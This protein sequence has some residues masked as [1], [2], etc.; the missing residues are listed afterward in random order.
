MIRAA[1]LLLALTGCPKNVEV[2]RA[3]TPA[4]GSP[5]SRP[6]LAWLSWSDANTLLVC[7][8]RVDDQA[9]TVGTPG[10]CLRVRAEQ[11]L[12]P[13]VAFTPA[14]ADRANA[15]AAPWSSCPLTL[16]DAQSVPARKAA[17]IMQRTPAGPRELEQ[18]MPGA[19]VQGDAFQLEASFSPNGKWMAI[20]RVAVG[21][22]EGERTVEIAGARL[23]PTP[24]CP[25]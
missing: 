13:G 11:P 17:R 24:D 23:V 5:G 6:H 25:N 18:W 2:K 10:P 7:N 19:Q 14:T 12:E 22:G 20:V 21:L 9:N 4:A 3:V 8:R 1:L 15:D 16:E